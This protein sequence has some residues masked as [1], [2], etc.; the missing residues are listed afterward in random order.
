LIG[1]DPSRWRTS[2]PLYGKVRYRG[3]Y[4][5]ID[6]VQYGK[7]GELEYDFVVSPGANPRLIGMAFPDAHAVHI[8]SNGDLLIRVAGGEIRHRKPAIYQDINGRR[9]TIHGRYVLTGSRAVR[10]E[11]ARYDHSRPL[12]IDPILIYLSYLGGPGSEAGT[13]VATDCS[14]NIYISAYTDSQMLPPVPLSTPGV[15]PMPGGG[16]DGDGHS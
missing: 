12:I 3:L 14:G 4:P 15:Q 13:G 5:G 11:V 16:L 8:D 7:E 6:L 10:I 2:I 1:N 9:A